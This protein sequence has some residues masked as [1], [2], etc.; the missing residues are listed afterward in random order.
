M[1]EVLDIQL[2]LVSALGR[3]DNGSFGNTFILSA[4]VEK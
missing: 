4:A 2:E 1:G 3:A